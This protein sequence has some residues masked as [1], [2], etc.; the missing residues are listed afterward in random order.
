[1]GIHALKQ[2]MSSHKH[3]NV[4]ELSVPQRHDLIPN[5]CVNH[6]VKI[7]NKTLVKLKKASPDTSVAAVDTDRDLHTRHG[8]HLNAHGKE[9][10]TKSPP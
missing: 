6:E 5:S 7:F 9:H 3:K 2:F 8:F 10:V 1:M 4:L